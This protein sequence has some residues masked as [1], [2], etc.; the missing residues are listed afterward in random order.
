ME[1]SQRP[2]HIIQHSEV[3]AW[4]ADS[5]VKVTTVHRTTAESAAAILRAGVHIEHT[6]VDVAWGRGFYTTNRPQRHAGDTNVRVA[7]RLRRPLVVDDPIEGQEQ[8][9]TLLREAGNEDI[10]AVLQGAGYDGVV[11]RFLDGEMWAVAHS[12]E[13]VKVVRG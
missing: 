2:A 1:R 3:A 9:D 5:I 12:D 11:V 6:A 7:V 8:I 4:L 13:Q 10:R